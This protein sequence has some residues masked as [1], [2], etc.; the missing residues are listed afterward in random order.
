MRVKDDYLKMLDDYTGQFA[1]S[2]ELTKEWFIKDL[3]DCWKIYQDFGIDDKLDL[4]ECFL[5]GCKTGRYDR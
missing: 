5:N 4:W 2:D 1:P 3:N